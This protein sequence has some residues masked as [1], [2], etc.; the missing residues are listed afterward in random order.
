MKHFQ[1]RL[2]SYY[3]SAR[4]KVIAFH[5]IC[6]ISIGYLHYT[7]HGFAL[8][9]LFRTVIPANPPIPAA[10]AH[11]PP[12]RLAVAGVPD[13]GGGMGAVAAADG[14]CDVTGWF[15]RWMLHLLLVVWRGISRRPLVEPTHCLTP[16]WI[17]LST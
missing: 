16:L 2:I 14:D 4:C 17:R 15:G 11:P 3:L 9:S 6:K 5:C 8:Y 13:E 12:H 10:R 7:T 1:K